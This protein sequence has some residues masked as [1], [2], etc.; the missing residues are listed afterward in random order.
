MPGQF[1]TTIYYAVCTC[2]KTQHFA[3][4]EAYNK[5][6]RYIDFDQYVYVSWFGITFAREKN[7]WAPKIVVSIEMNVGL[8]K[9]MS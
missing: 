4:S 9:V 2:K 5:G 7:C 6:C 8:Y 1:L 3:R